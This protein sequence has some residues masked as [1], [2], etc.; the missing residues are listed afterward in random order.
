M[1]MEALGTAQGLMATHSGK[2]AVSGTSITFLKPKVSGTEYLLPKLFPKPFILFLKS[3]PKTVP[4][5][6]GFRSTETVPENIAPNN[7][8]RDARVVVPLFW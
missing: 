7:W 1:K 2:S 3:A 8:V 4:E 6:F 5:T